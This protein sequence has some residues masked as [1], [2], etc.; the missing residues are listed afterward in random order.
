MK[1][2][3]MRTFLLQVESCCR[4]TVRIKI[5]IKEYST[6]ELLHQ[7]KYAMILWS[8]R[9]QGGKPP[10]LEIEGRWCEWIHTKF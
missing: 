9:V 7:R 3:Y 8:N 1:D 4:I 2:A 6:S 10:V 5:D